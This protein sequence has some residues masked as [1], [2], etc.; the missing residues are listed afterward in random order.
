[1]LA[2]RPASFLLVLALSMAGCATKPEQPKTKLVYF[3]FDNHAEKAENALQLAKIW[4]EHPPCPHWR[5]TIKKE[6][7]DYEV[8][9]GTADITI[10]DRRGQVLYGGGTGVLYQPHGNPDGSGV[11]I[12][13][14]TGE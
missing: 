3:G 8:L 14:L 13:K 4:G 9:F 10:T 1:M 6:A 11:N 12:C 2:S 7:A 5:A